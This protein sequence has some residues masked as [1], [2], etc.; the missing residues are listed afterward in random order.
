MPIKD[1]LKLALIAL[2][3]PVAIILVALLALPI[4]NQPKEN[5]PSDE[6]VPKTIETKENKDRK[7]RNYFELWLTSPSDKK[8]FFRDPESVPIENLS[9]KL[10]AGKLLKVRSWPSPEGNILLEIV[11]TDNRE[12]ILSFEERMHAF[13]FRQR[14]IGLV[15]GVWFLVFSGVWIALARVEVH[16]K[17]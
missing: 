12:V 4:P 3:V 7:G 9:T 2:G 6:F 13:A 15:A 10:P 5:F 1:H 16:S 11:R 14:F 17:S 8:Y